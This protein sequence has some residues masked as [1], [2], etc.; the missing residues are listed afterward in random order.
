[1][2]GLKQSGPG[3][4]GDVKEKRR[5]ELARTVKLLTVGRRLRKMM[6]ALTELPVREG[7]QSDHSALL[8]DHKGMLWE[9]NQCL[10]ES[11]EAV[12]T[13]VLAAVQ[14]RR[15]RAFGFIQ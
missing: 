1:M 9:N 13:G 6:D 2:G 10:S 8:M 5:T 12:S 4:E 15:H 7:H 3:E 14:V 11:F